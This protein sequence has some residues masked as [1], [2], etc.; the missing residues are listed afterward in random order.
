[1][2]VTYELEVLRDGS[3]PAVGEEVTNLG[4]IDVE[5]A[6]VDVDWDLATRRLTRVRIAI[7]GLPLC[8]DPVSGSV[9]SRTPK[10]E[11]RAFAA[12]SYVAN[13][14][15]VETGLDGIDPFA[16]VNGSPSITAETREEEEELANSLRTVSTSI[17]F[18]YSV[19]CLLRQT[20]WERWAALAA[21]ARVRNALA[22]YAEGFRVQSPFLRFEQF[23]KVLDHFFPTLDG[24]RLD[25]AVAAHLATH[26]LGITQDTIT[27]L[28]ELR[29]RSMH[30]VPRKAGLHLS[31]HQ[32]SSLR[33]V[34]ANLSKMQHVAEQLLR[35][36][37]AEIGTGPQR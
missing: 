10:I 19:Y 1:M 5:G 17:S 27:A 7:S 4:V 25:A 21:D 3:D 30:A 37:P 34:A 18:S 14:L 9:L 35:H 31:P 32:L 15:R 16:V 12:A 11:A 8:R 20:D 23:Y 33:E 13:L 24:E 6:V 26:D 2:R 29:I 36:P 28:R 22:N